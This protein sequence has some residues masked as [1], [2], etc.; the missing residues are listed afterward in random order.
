MRLRRTRPD[1]HKVPEREIAA[2]VDMDTSISGE[3]YRQRS[4]VI[5][6]PVDSRVLKSTLHGLG[7]SY[8]SGFRSFLAA[9]LISDGLVIGV[10][11][12]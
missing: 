12:V 2:I 4:G 7:P 5:F 10:L 8:E 6:Q 1:T 11:L 3:V 9:P